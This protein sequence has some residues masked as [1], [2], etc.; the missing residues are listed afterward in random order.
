MMKSEIHNNM[1]Q[2]VLMLIEAKLTFNKMW[3][4][5]FLGIWD[6]HLENQEIQSQPNHKKNQHQ[7]KQ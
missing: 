7:L 5:F 6:L 1:V 3:I 2:Q 4:L